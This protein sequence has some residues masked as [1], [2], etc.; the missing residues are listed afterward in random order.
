MSIID[1]L[2]DLANVA[3]QTADRLEATTDLDARMTPNGDMS[4]KDAYLALREVPSIVIGMELSRYGLEGAPVIT[5]S[6]WQGNGT[7]R[8]TAATMRQAVESITGPLMSPA[9]REAAELARVQAAVSR[10]ANI[11]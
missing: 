2:R 8:R 10:R 4:F 7:E 6:V 9:D 1:Q 3:I 5:F 11:V